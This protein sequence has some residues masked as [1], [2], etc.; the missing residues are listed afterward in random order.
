MFWRKTQEVKGHKLPAPR[1]TGTG[2]RLI[3]TYLA[4]PF[5]LVLTL[6]DV[7]LYFYFKLALDSCYGVLCLF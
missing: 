3:L 2:L 1:L 4:L 5:L 7:A 6:M